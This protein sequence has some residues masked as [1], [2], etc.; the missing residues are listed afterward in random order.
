MKAPRNTSLLFRGHDGYLPLA[1]LLMCTCTSAVLSQKVKYEEE[2]WSREG[3]EY[4]CNEK[5]LEHTVGFN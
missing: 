5:R 4:L 1:E 2:E 3:V